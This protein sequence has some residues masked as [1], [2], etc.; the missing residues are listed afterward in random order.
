[1]AWSEAEPKTGVTPSTELF[2]FCRSFKNNER[3]SGK[4]DQAINS[5]FPKKYFVVPA[6]FQAWKYI[7]KHDLNI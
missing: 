5:I 7:L 3:K 4:F 6:Y 1:M 2:L